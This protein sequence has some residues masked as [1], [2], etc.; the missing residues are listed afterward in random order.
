[1]ENVKY[2]VS[3]DVGCRLRGFTLDIDLL[4]RL[5]IQ[6]IMGW[7]REESKLHLTIIYN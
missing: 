4:L 6:E 7:M 5:I 2:L 1:M 3:I